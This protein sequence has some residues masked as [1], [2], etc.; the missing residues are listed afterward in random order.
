VWQVVLLKVA[1]AKPYADFSMHLFA[2]E[3]CLNYIFLKKACT[4]ATVLQLARALQIF[5]IK[6]WQNNPYYIVLFVAAAE[7]K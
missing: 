4:F 2:N 7:M 3:D 1:L 5:K 6:P